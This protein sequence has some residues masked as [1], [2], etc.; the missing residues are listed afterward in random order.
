MIKKTNWFLIVILFLTAISCDDFETD[1]NV[2][3]PNDPDA[4]AILSDKDALNSLAGSMFHTWF[5]TT[6]STKGPGAAFNTMADISTCSWGNF[7]MKDL[8]SEPRSTFNNSTSYGNDVTSTYFDDMYSVYANSNKLLAA[9]DNG[10]EFDDVNS[11]KLSANMGLALSIGYLSLVFDK[12]LIVENGEVKKI[13]YKEGMTFALA[14]LDEAI[15]LADAGAGLPD[16][17]IPGATVDGASMSKLL[18]SFGARML[19]NNVRNSAQKSNIDWNKVKTYATNGINA[20]FKI[21]MDDVNWYDLIPKTYLVYPGWGRVDMRIIHLMDSNTIDY[22]SDTTTTVAE[23][24]SSDLRLATDFKYLSANN[25]RPNRGLYHFS[26]YRYSRYD[27]YISVWVMDLVEYTKSENDMYL[28]EAELELGN[29]SV[30][31]NIVNAGT[32]TTRGGLANVATNVQD[33]HDAIFYERMVE[34]GFSTMGI[35]FFEMRKENLLQPGTLL[36]F[37]IPG[38]TLETLNEDIYSFGGTSGVA[39]EDYSNGGWRN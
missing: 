28:A 25:F 18:N 26:S 8:S 20:D 19:V 33:V 17:S 10:I 12:I 7:G 27:D 23:S 2:E 30:A 3:N 15:A 34:F 21:H 16:N 4:T 31:A 24:T 29:T 39:G 22:W 1:L 14:R 5:M 9:I 32:R 11:I 37:P 38:K 6:A 13:D 35:G 36:H